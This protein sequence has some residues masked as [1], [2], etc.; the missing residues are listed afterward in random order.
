[1]GVRGVVDVLAGGVGDRPGDRPVPKRPAADHRQR[2]RSP[3]GGVRVPAFTGRGGRG[4]TS[5]TTG[6]IWMGGTGFGDHLDGISLTFLE[7]LT[8]GRYAKILVR[9]PASYIYPITYAESVRRGR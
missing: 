2:C 7:H 8:P 6:V 9:Y 1:G 4:G 5:M 3:A